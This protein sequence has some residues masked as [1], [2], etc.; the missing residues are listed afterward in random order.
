MFLVPDQAKSFIVASPALLLKTMIFGYSSNKVVLS[1]VFPGMLTVL[2]RQRLTMRGDVKHNTTHTAVRQGAKYG[3]NRNTSNNKISR[4]EGAHRERKISLPAK[5]Q[6][7][8]SKYAWS[9]YPGTLLNTKPE[10]MEKKGGSTSLLPSNKDTL[11]TLVR[12]LVTLSCFSPLLQQSSEQ[13]NLKRER[14][15]KPGSTL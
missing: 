11:S 10:S 3:W 5:I 6:A 12:L 9:R 13:T 2:L 7:V 1:H 14:L 4:F 8:Y 15:S